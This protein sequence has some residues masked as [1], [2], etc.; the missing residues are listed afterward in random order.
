MEFCMPIEEGDSEITLGVLNAVEQNSHIT[1]RDVAKNIGIA[2]GLTN[3]YVKRCIRK[4][5]IKVQ[6]VPVNRYA[7]YLTPNGFAEKSRLTAEFL[8]QGFQFFRLARNQCLEIFQNCENSGWNNIALHGLTD[9]AEIAVLCAINFDLEIVG[10]IDNSTSLKR[11]A[12][13]KVVADISELGDFD[14]IIITDLGDPQSSYEHM[15]QH[16]PADRVFSPG[17]LNISSTD[18]VL[19]IN[20]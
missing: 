4:G 13:K 15:L 7:Y 9:L 14:A 5:L 20:K 17:I 12:E 16:F 3:T 18:H 11:Y 6:Q 2:L 8:T 19:R 10:I 1:Q